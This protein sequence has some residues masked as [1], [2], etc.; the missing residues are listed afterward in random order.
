M[1]D[2]WLL[3][4]VAAVAEDSHLTLD[5]GV[6]VRA[7]CAP[8]ECQKP[9]CAHKRLDNSGPGMISEKDRITCWAY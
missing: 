1:S 7:D 6:Y 2:N 8:N 3:E 4:R 9:L 5:V